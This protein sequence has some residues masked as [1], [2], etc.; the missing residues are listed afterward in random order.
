[1]NQKARFSTILAKT[2][3][4]LTLTD[5]R[6]PVICK[7]ITTPTVTTIAA[8]QVGAHRVGATVMEAS[9]TFIYI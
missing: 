4:G 9:C 8:R 1:M 5:A 7:L 6:V 2:R 3:N